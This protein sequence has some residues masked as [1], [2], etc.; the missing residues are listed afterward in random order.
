VYSGGRGEFDSGECAD[1]YDVGS[2]DYFESEGL[3]CW[4]RR[5]MGRGE[6][7]KGMRRG[8]GKWGEKG[9]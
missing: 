7:G 2:D 6:R 3:R 1:E 5:R 9:V 8:D 4:E